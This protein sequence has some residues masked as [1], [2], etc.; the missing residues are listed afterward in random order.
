MMQQQPLAGLNIVVTR[1]REQATNLAQRI[2][3]AGGRAIL[4]PLLEVSPVLDSQSLRALIARLH[5]FNLAIFISPN[6]VRYGME[7]IITAS[8][9]LSPSQLSSFNFFPLANGTDVGSTAGEGNVNVSSEQYNALPASL[10]IAT[11]G[12]GSVRALRDYGVKNVI[13]PQDRFDSE[14][15]LALPELKQIAGWRVVIFR[16]NGGRELLGDTLKA[17]GVKV[18]YVTCYQRARPHQDATMLL[19][20]NPDAITVTSSEALGYLWDM[21]DNVAKKRLAAVPLF[22]PHARIAEAAHKLGWS[23]VVLT[24]EGDDGLIS[25]LIA[26]AKKNASNRIGNK[27]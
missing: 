13:A 20:A 6:A 4:F 18:E 24:D 21:L 27:P 11:V 5:E 2:A 7:A 8:K 3:Q 17:R 9:S 10:K 15:L 16:G 26:W 19:A 25:G 14:A 12:Q 23:E 22:V 1:P